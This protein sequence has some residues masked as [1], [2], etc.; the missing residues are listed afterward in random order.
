MIIA[1]RFQFHCR[2]QAVGETVAEYEAELHK[3]A[4]HCAFG[5]YVSEAISDCIVCGLQ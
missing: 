1:E 2:N 5:D 3:L 4:T